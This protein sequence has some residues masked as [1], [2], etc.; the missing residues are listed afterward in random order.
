MK[1]W[2]RVFTLGLV[3]LV[4][5]A[6][7]T[8]VAG[9]PSGIVEIAATLVGAIALGVGGS[10]LASALVA[11]LVSRQ[12]FGIDVAEAVEALRGA[13]ALSRSNQ[14]L[15]IRLD[16]SG[17]EVR[18]VAEH[19]FDLLAS[20]SRPK[21]IPFRLYTDIARWGSA[22]GFYSVVEPD[23][24][25]LSGEGLERHVENIAEKARFEKT[26][27]FHPHTPATF[28]IETF[29]LFRLSDRLIWTVEHI[30]SDFKVRVRDCTG[31]TGQ[32]D[33]KVNHHREAEISAHMVR[34]ESPQGMVL[35]FAF[36]GE[37]LPFQGFELQW[38][39]HE[40][41]ATT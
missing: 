6:L 21:K 23:G 10:V 26:Y 12:V 41:E 40:P 39:F 15:E 28:V 17:D 35:D 13:S 11:R 34:R 32:V 25:V 27:V 1:T 30:S 4:V 20:A 38:T 31:L 2:Q 24:T 19:R 3:V 16:I 9:H 29:G 5:G 37:V 14:L 7:A 8:L 22:G 18:A 33:V 36:L